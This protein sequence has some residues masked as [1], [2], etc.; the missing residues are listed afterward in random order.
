MSSESPLKPDHSVDRDQWSDSR[1][2]SNEPSSMNIWL[3]ADPGLASVPQKHLPTL[4]W[5]S[6]CRR[7][8]LLPDKAGSVFALKSRWSD[9]T[10]F[11][12]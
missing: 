1:I 10:A 8:W 3:M 9:P 4:E 12:T 7:E 2:K 11:R 6:R 5:I